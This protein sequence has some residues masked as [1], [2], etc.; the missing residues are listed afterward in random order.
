VLDGI[1]RVLAPDGCLYLGG[2]ETVLGISE[3]FQAA[4]DQR[5]IYMLAPAAAPQRATG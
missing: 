5:G 1:A 2:A 4:A 3:R